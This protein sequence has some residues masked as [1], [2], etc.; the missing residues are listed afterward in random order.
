MKKIK[1]TALAAVLALAPAA[2]FADQPTVVYKSNNGRDAQGT[3]DN[4]VGAASSQIIHN[5]QIIAE[6]GFVPG[7]TH[8]D[9]PPDSRSNVVQQLLGHSK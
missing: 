9:Q 3:I 7:P 4:A 5:S 1:L 2:A 8:G 6:E